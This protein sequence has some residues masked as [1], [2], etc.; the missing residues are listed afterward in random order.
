M[1]EETVR[2]F[3]E[4]D[5]R[6]LSRGMALVLLGAA[7]LGCVANST[8]SSRFGNT[9]SGPEGKLAPEIQGVDADG[10]KFALS[11]YRGKVVLL[12]FWALW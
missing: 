6:K 1:D 3:G 11:E 2:L 10:K 9:K 8:H 4:T 7:F 5:M 12:D